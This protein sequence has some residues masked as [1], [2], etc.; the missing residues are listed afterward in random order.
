MRP[1]LMLI[2]FIF[3]LTTTPGYSET[4]SE[5]YASMAG[6]MLD[7]FEC[8][9]LANLLQY[10][11]QSKKFYEVGVEIGKQHLD[12]L[13]S[14]RITLIDQSSKMPATIA[15]APRDQGSEFILGMAFQN[16]ENAVN[17]RLSHLLGGNW[18]DFESSDRQPAMQQMYGENSC[19]S[20]L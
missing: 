8:H 20:F 17:R 15:N 6:R 7:A 9:H 16:A 19:F 13:L 14:D 3:V 12:A 10:F 4:R 2:G 11:D 1:L 5:R 18:W